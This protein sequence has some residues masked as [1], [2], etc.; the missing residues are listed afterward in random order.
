[1]D[2]VL[3][4]ERFVSIVAHEQNGLILYWGNGNEQYIGPSLLTMNT[5]Y[6]GV[7]IA[8]INK[9]GYLDILAGG[10]CIDRD[11][12]EKHGIAIFWGS[13]KGFQN[14]NRQIIHHNIEKM[15]APLLMDLNRDN[16]LD[17]TAQE[18]DGKIK[19]WWG[20]EAGYND[21]SLQ[22][23]DLGRPDHLMYIK[24]ADLN[25]DG[26]LDLLLP[27]RRPHEEINTGLS[28]GT[29]TIKC[30]LPIRKVAI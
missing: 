20:S 6:G 23:I 25:K 14:H 1:M 8:D 4:Q 12:P 13:A 16:W 29:S 2:I 30:S 10:D 26:W 17:I 19:I 21:D 24:G 28:L 27:K 15:R 11:D 22:E 9:D 18:N 5:A 3:S 7:R